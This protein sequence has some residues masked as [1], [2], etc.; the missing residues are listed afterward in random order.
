MR[1]T[2]QSHSK[3]AMSKQQPSF[4]LP[5]LDISQP[6]RL[7]ALPSIFQACHECGF[8]YI[9]NHGLSDK[10]LTALYSQSKQ[11]F[12]LPTEYKLKLGPS[13]SIKS[14]TPRH[15]ASPFYEGLVVSGSPDFFSSAMNS[16]NELYVDAA[17]SEFW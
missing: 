5:I 3:Y 16:I 13:S 6:L 14:Y 8:F 17:N 4:Q 7:S 9:T 12:S 15:I 10:L 11:L 2:T 1:K